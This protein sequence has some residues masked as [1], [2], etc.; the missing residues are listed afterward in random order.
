MQ[1]NKSIQKGT[2]VKQTANLK[3]DS[4]SSSL[5][6]GLSTFFQTSIGK[7]NIAYTIG[8]KTVLKTA[9]FKG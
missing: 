3:V 8:F 7:H 5:I 6:F 2:N 9:V 4:N 1:N